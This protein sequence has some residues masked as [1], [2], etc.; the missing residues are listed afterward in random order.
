TLRCVDSF[1]HDAS[2]HATEFEVRRSELPR[3][4]DHLACGTEIDA[5]DAP[6][7]PPPAE[8]HRLILAPVG[9][10]AL[11]LFPVR[12]QGHVVGAL[13]LEDP[14]ELTESRQFLRLLA[15]MGAL[16]PSDQIREARN[17]EP[18]DPGVVVRESER[19]HSL[20]ADL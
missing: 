16:R 9:R 4:S 17:S 11:S 6:A 15:N 2:V 5:S 7:A 19:V 8:L 20:S 12:R 13:W 18:A 10:R 1:Q 14:I 3:F